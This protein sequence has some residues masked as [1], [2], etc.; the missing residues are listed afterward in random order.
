V[1][2]D[3]ST[4]IDTVYSAQS[5][6]QLFAGWLRQRGKS[7]FAVLSRGRTENE[8]DPTYPATAHW[9]SSGAKYPKQAYRLRYIYDALKDDQGKRRKQGEKTSEERD[10]RCQKFYEASTKS[11][12]NGGIFVIWCPHSICYGCT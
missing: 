4:G 3:P 1:V 2:P 8:L 5:A 6:L 11:R 9:T 7:I 12:Q 10:P